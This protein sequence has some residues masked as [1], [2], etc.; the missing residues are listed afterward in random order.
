MGIWIAC[1]SSIGLLVEAHHFAEFVGEG[2]VLFENGKIVIAG[3][4]VE[5]R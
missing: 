3:G 1:R 2:V 4:A 5:V